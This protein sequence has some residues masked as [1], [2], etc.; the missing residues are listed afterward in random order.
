LKKPFQTSKG[1]LNI[2]MEYAEAG[3]LEDVINQ[4]AKNKEPLSEEKV[5][6]YFS[7]LCLAISHAHDC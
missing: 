3:T 5:M 4:Q 1:D 2:V 6:D 7:Q